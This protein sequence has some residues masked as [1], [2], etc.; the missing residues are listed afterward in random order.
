MYSKVESASI[1]EENTLQTELGTIFLKESNQDYRE[2]FYRTQPQ[3]F[4]QDLPHYK[5]LLMPLQMPNSAHFQPKGVNTLPVL[6]SM[7]NRLGL[8]T[9][10]N[11]PSSSK[12]RKGP[13]SSNNLTMV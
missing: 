12:S 8:G 5:D 9:N 1:I 6:S 4:S 2:E 13:T 11:N 10:F 3:G 7:M